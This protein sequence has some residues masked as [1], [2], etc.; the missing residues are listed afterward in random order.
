MPRDDKSPNVDPRIRRTERAVIAA[1]KELFETQG[2]ASTTMTQIAQ[3]AE[4][5]PR[6]LFLRFATKADLLR[7]VVDATFAGLA[8]PGEGLTAARAR[9]KAGTLDERLRAFAEGVAD[10]LVRTGPLFAVA[11]EAEAS[12]PSIR[13]GFDEARRD[14][15]ANSHR[16]WQHLADD[17]LLHP[18]VDVAWVADTTGLLASADT[19]LLMSTT[20]AW[21]RDE[22]AAWLHR[23]W[24]HFATTPSR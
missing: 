13:A 2:Y 3:H 5:A 21:S 1:A 10:V 22:L 8:E 9:L 19:Y 4:C 17:G 20:L 14:T 11:R 23:T 16:M 6:T 7:R 18:D 15:L 12:E 24:T